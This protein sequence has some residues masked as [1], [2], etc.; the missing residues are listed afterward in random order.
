MVMEPGRP[1]AG[2]AVKLETYITMIDSRNITVNCS[3][4]NSSM[5]TIV[6]P[7]KLLVEGEG[8]GETYLIKGYT[9]C[10]MD[11][12]RYD[13]KLSEPKVEDKIVFLNAGAYNIASDFCNLS[14]PKTVITD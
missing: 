12:F 11:I 5:D 6:I 2:P 13:V 10:T 3:V 7:H 8:K 1:I 9:P 4:Y 14:K